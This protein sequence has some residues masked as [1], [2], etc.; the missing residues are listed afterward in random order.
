MLY[1]LPSLSFSYDAMQPH[2]DALTMKLHYT[3]HHTACVGN[4]NKMLEGSE[5][6]LAMSLEEILYDIRVVPEAIRQAVRNF[7]GAHLNHS[8]FWHTMAPSGG[9]IPGGSFGKVLNDC[10]G[11]FYTFKQTFTKTAMERFGS[12]WAWLG[13]GPYN[14]LEV[15]STPN[16]DSPIMYGFRPILGV[17]LWEHA[18]YLT[19]QNRKADYIEAWWNLVN[20]Q[21]V[22]ELY[23]H[24]AETSR[25]A[26]PA[27]P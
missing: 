5:K 14:D 15:L 6:L 13:V 21:R 25:S 10:F 23:L 12:G 24:C 19:Y 7:A 18:Y 17:D 26:H 27:K 16:E 8:L 4:L 20:W 9:G 11:D 3:R 1:Q 22:G 2:I